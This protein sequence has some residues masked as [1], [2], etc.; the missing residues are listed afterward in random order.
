MTQN[1]DDYAGG[2]FVR[3]LYLW[4]IGLVLFFAFSVGPLTAAFDQGRWM[5]GTPGPS[6]RTEVAVAA[7]DGLIY[8]VGGFEKV[9]TGPFFFDVCRG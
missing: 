9:E 3:I 7:L 1:R 5:R 4:G 6:E 8:V 2:K